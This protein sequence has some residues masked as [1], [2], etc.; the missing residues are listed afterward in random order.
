MQRELCEELLRVGNNSPSL[1]YEISILN[2]FA[3]SDK[4]KLFPFFVQLLRLRSAE[5]YCGILC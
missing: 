2:H 5:I 3:I 1:L 4:L